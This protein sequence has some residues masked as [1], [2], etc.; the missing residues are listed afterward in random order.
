M[1]KIWVIYASPTDFPGV[2]FVMRQHHIKRPKGGENVV[3]PTEHFWTGA[4]IEELRRRIP[5]DK[6]RMPRS[7]DDEPQIVEWWF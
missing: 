7:D 4:S 5:Q 3:T 1:I 6:T 2:A